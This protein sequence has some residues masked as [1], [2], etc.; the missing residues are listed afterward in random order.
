[1]RQYLTG[2]EREQYHALTPLAQ[3]SWLL[4]RIAAKDAVRDWLWNQGVG[5]LFPAEVEVSNGDRGQPHV[6]GRF[7]ADLRISLA[8][9][10]TLAVAMVGLG[11]PV[12]IDIEVVEP[13][14]DA[15]AAIVLTD[16]ER[17]LVAAADRDRTLT[18]LWVAKEAVAKA[19]GTG[20]KGRPK[21]FEVA[22][23]TGDALL[24]GD[25]WIDTEIVTDEKG[26]EFIVGWTRIDP[27]CA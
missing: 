20:L 3:R 21:D 15:F 26:D 18:R 16:A 7:D 22:A 24:V 12:G 25:R 8:H 17:D 14:D 19:A 5:P 1:M 23:I 2:P 13:R 27:A 6:R 11:K 10:R 9:S 4:G